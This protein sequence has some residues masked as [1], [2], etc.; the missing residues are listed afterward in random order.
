MYQFLVFPQL[1]PRLDDHDSGY[2]PAILRGQDT[3][4]KLN[5]K[6]HAESKRVIRGCDVQVRDIVLGN[7]PKLEMLSTPYHSIPLTVT[8]Q[9]RIIVWQQLK[10]HPESDM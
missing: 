9:A 7:Q 8:I 4:H 3:Q 10:V 1:L 6:C 2:D 5:M